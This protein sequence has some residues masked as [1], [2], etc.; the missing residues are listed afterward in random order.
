VSTLNLAF[1][2]LLK[3]RSTA[4]V[5]VLTLA[6]GIAANLIVFAMVNAALIRP[7][8]FTDPDR[9]V[10]LDDSI[11]GKPVGVSWGEIEELEHA[12]ALFEGAAAYAG[13]TWALTDHTGNGLDVILSGMVTPDFFRVLQPMPALGAAFTSDNEP[14]VVVL[15]YA[16]WQKRYHGDPNVTAQSLA[17]NDV[18]YRIVG[19]L[20]KRFDFPM[21]GESPDLYI[22]L[23]RKDYCCR[24]DARGLSGIAR[25]APGVSLATASQHLT[26][27]AKTVANDNNYQQFSYIPISLQAFLAK[28]VERILLFLWLA[29]TLLGIIAALN[30]GAVLLARSLRNLPQY[31]L[32]ISLGASVRHLLAEQLA[33]AVILAAVASVLAAGLAHLAFQVLRASPVFQPLL[34]RVAHAGSLWDWRVFGF[35]AGLSLFAAVS[36]CLLPLAILRGMSPEQVLRSHSR[37]STSRAGRRLRTTLI[38]CSTRPQRG[39]VLGGHEL[40]S[41]PLRN[42]QPK[43]W[44]PHTK[45][46]HSRYWSS[47][48]P[49]R[50]R[51]QDDRLPR[52]RDRIHA[53]DPRRQP[54]RIRGWGTHRSSPHALFA[55]R[56]PQHSRSRPPPLGRRFCQSGYLPHA[57][58]DSHPR[59]K[60]FP[61]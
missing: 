33:Q 40:R 8:P 36:A 23:D 17:L 57:R 49:L 25:L 31:A 10:A 22:P 13:R 60:I 58:S 15:S 16:L 21:A 48:R 1:R 5:V 42:A 54:C 3:M 41:R 26:A 37:L 11:N 61:S 53:F 51:R 44:F 20:P 28:D 7:L 52:A 32:K 2:T 29:V 34:G 55:G 46:C 4:L 45:H 18:P 56:L 50:Y 9:L 27:I 35:C 43:S 19:V 30:A 59:P 39:L 12:P 24:F 38:V 6:T 14:H 47:G